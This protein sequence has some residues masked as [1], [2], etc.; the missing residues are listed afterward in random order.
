M[1]ID[2]HSHM[3]GPNQLGNFHAGLLADRGAHGRGHIN[4][5][6]EEL[7]RQMQR[8]MK[9]AVE[10]QIDFQL[11]SPRPY[12]VM[13]WIQPHKLVRW[14]IEEVNNIIARQV[15]LHPDKLIGV[16]SL[17]Q[18]VG[19]LEGCVE[20]LERCVKELGFVGCLINPDPA[21]KGD[22]T[23]PGMGDEFWYPLY[24]KLVELDVPALIHPAACQLMRNPTFHLHFINE[25]STAIMSM[26]EYGVFETMGPD[27][28]VYGTEVPG[29]GTH[30]HPETGVQMDH[31]VPV[32]ESIEFLSAE[33]KKMIFE[34][35]ARR[36]YKLPV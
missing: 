31:L 35:N 5:S 21:E 24:E 29:A 11:I 27:R 15:K 9:Q 8:G 25:E 16:C 14:Y 33:D 32:I 6:D 18:G 13:Q 7:D 17:P 1:I 22:D 2:A 30:P 12:T 28:C 34:D 4:I 3:N 36:L 10:A 20:E 23:T 26:V 19:T